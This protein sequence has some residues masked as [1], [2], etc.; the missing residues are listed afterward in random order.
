M[1]INKY[2]NSN[3]FLII[4]FCL[5]G[6]NVSAQN[7]VDQLKTFH[8][9]QS[10]PKLFNPGTIIKYAIGSNQYA[11][12][13]VYDV[14]GNEIATLVNEEK[15]AGTYEVEFNAAGLPSGIYFYGL[16]AG[17]FVETKKMVLIR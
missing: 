14:L 8:L 13:I 1:I 12:L 5:G 4:L 2:I 16:Q 11:S 17:S 15:P 10:Y 6:L 3:L 9:N 7:Q